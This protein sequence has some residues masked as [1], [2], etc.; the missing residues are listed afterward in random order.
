VGFDQ[1][2]LLTDA[3]DQHPHCVLLLD[4]IEKAHPDLFNILLQ[5]MDHGKLTDHNGKSVNF[6]N[7][8]L[9]MTTNAGA[10]ELAKNAIGFGQETREGEDKEAIERMFTPEFRNRLDAIIT[11]ANLPPEV[12]GR[13]VDKFVMELEGQLSDR[14]VTIE[15]T[16]A[17]RNWLSKKGYDSRMG[18]RPLGR[19]IQQEIKKPLADQLLFGDLITGGHVK[20]DIKDNKVSFDVNAAKA[21]PKKSTKA[22]GK[23]RG[24]KNSGKGGTKKPETV[25]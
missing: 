22:S 10:A 5:V 2:G 11:F 18:A 1:G 4:E 21:P 9:I 13:V 25:R 6:R 17:A 14:N 12:V 23:S 7:V 19:V 3:V 8:I 20:V 15:L 24:S 16:P